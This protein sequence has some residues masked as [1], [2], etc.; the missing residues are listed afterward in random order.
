MIPLQ[1]TGPAFFFSDLGF[2]PDVVLIGKALGNGFPVSGVVVDRRHPV[3]PEM[4][5][6]STYA[7]NA[8]ASAAVS[9]TLEQIRELDLPRRVAR[10]EATIVQALG[11]L[12]A[13]GA[14][15]RGRGAVAPAPSI[16]IL[17]PRIVSP[18]LVIRSRIKPMPSVL[19]PMI[20]LS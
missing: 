12:E 8:L 11:G 16:R 4:L 17:A 20:T 18:R 9:A 3:R 7:G 6:N 10:I 1:R 5:P 15:L 14:A 2:E 13:I 19:S